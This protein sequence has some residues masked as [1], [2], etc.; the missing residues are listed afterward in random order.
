MKLLA[1]RN[2][3][4][5]LSLTSG[6]LSPPVLYFP[7]SLQG[8]TPQQLGNP[9][10][11]PPTLPDNAG[12]PGHLRLPGVT[13]PQPEA[14]LRRGDLTDPKWFTVAL[15]A[16]ANGSPANPVQRQDALFVRYFRRRPDGRA[17]CSGVVMQSY[18]LFRFQ[19]DHGVSSSCV[20]RE[21]DLVHNRDPVLNHRA[22]LGR[23]P[24]PVRADLPEAQP[25]SASQYPL[26]EPSCL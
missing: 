20:V 12:Y 7:C 8:P 21:L 9:E 15:R 11:T 19:C 16:S 18:Q 4:V 5:L 24:S 10:K 23:A 3:S 2:N 1:L 22:D 17:G 25:L 13:V 6:L 26:P 14:I